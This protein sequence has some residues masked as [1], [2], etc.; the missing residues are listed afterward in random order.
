VIVVSNATPLI[1]LAK[2]RYFHLLQK[3]FAEITITEETW[4][5]VVVNGAGRSGSAE[6][7]Q[8]SWI[9]VK[10]L[11]DPTQLPMWQSEYKLGVGEVSTILLAKELSADL[12][13]IDERKARILATSEGLTLSGSIAVLE[14]GYRK[15]YVT[16]LRQTYLNLLAAKIWIDRKVLKQSLANLD[17]L[18]L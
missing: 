17:L 11:A 7:A 14:S 15:K 2:V 6:T 4:N 5:E 10:G 8:A 12:T 13:L 1:T 16:D 9:Q 3:L 18:P